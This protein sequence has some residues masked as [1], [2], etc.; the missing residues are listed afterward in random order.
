MGRLQKKKRKKYGRLPNQGG[1]RRVEKN[2]TSILGSKKGQKWPKT[3]QK[4]ILFV[5]KDQTVRGG[6]RSE[7]GLVKNLTFYIFF[8]AS[9]PKW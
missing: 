7:G 8:P 1:S 2:Q 3:R 6:G 4:L 5:K 9:F